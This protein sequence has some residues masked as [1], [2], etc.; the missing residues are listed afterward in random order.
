[1]PVIQWKLASENLSWILKP[2]AEINHKEK[3]VKYL[4]CKNGQINNAVQDDLVKDH[5]GEDT[6]T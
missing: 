6:L 3:A 1:M 5:L 2:N 4:A